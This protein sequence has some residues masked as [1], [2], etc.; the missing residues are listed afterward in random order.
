MLYRVEGNQVSALESTTFADAG[1]YEKNIEDWVEERP[2]LLGE[3]LIV[4]GRQV[5]LDEGKDIV[6]LLA[7]DRGANL[8]IVEL[9][10]DLLGGAA[11]L[12]PIRYAALL[13]TWTHEHVRRQAEG[14]WVTVGADRGTFAQEVEEFCDDEAQV[15]ADQRV[16]LAGRELTPRLG[17]VAVWL[18]SHGVDA[19][20]VTI[21]AFEHDGDLLLQ[22]QVVIP[23]PSQQRIAG[24]VSGSDATKPWKVDGPAWHLEQRL[25]QKGRAIA[26][27]VVAAVTE[28][29]PD[30]VGPNW[31]Q[32]NYVSW[33]RASRNWLIMYTDSPNQV[34][35]I[36]PSNAQDA[37][38]TVETLQWSEF[39]GELTLSEK[40]AMGSSVGVDSKGRLRLIVKSEDDVAG[41]A[42]KPFRAALEML[43]LSQKM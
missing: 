14:Y 39:D 10:R 17:T 13:S 29:T 30:A 4:I 8:V 11:D 25:N 22:P 18:R 12:Q 2:E 38:L 21:S 42:G 16:V 23:V 35:L 7:L 5:A 43:W 6:D 15:N 34:A 28:A 9:K 36:L 41:D 24:S 40:L 19:T 3:E 31:A 32:K 20:V 37:A 27:A 1:V 26:E 33:L